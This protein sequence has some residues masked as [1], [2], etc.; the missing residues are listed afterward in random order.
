M[1]SSQW[2]GARNRSCNR[3]SAIA[4]GVVDDDD[5]VG[6]TGL[7]EERMQARGKEVLLVVR[8]HDYAQR[9]S[10]LDC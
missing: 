5:L 8:A 1:R 3:M 4:T 2:S 9:P 7:G 10:H 6:G